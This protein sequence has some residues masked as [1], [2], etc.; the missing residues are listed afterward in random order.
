MLVIALGWWRALRLVGVRV[1]LRDAL[2]WYFVGQLGKYVPGGIWSVVGSAELAVGGGSSRTKAYGSMVLSLGAA[3]LAGIVTVVALLPAHPSLMRQMPAVGL[4][5]VLAPIGVLLVHPAAVRW[6]VR[7]GSRVAG[8]PIDIEVPA[9]SASLR[10]VLRHVPAWMLVGIATWCVT[11]SLGVSA[12]LISV[13]MAS[14]LA[15]VVGFLVVPAPGGLGV[16]EAVFTLAAAPLSPGL[17]A[18]VAVLS[19]LLFIIVDLCGGAILT[20]LHPRRDPLVRE[21]DPV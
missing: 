6:M 17:A 8:R 18:A 15:W 19:R 1:S 13:G 4:L 10:L 14:V 2:R 20:L 3:Y 16:R 5:A 7:A 11:R 12:P 9:W 21:G